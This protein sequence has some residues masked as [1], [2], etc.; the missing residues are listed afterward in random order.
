MIKKTAPRKRTASGDNVHK[1]TKSAKHAFA[2][3]E[4]Y[5]PTGSQE[6]T[7]AGI[8]AAAGGALLAAAVLGVGPAALAGRLVTSYTA[9]LVKIERRPQVV[10]VCRYQ[11][12]QTPFA[13]DREGKSAGAE[14]DRR[15]SGE[16]G[17]SSEWH[18]DALHFHRSGV[19]G[20]CA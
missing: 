8:A 2:K 18:G 20:R 13:V 17:L 6:R 19:D 14:G 9:K 3:I 4:S 11:V 5:L 1:A 12:C 10:E 16:Y 15:P 7:T